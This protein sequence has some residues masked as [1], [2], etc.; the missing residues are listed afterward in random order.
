[1]AKLTVNI[2]TT[3]NDRTGDNL[4]TAFTKINTNFTE[5][6]NDVENLTSR[7]VVVEGS[8]QTGGLQ[9]NTLISNVQGSI[10]AEDSTILVNAANNTLQGD[11]TGDVTG[12]IKGNVFG[13]DSSL[14]V[15]ADNNTVTADLTGN[16]TG[17]VTGNVTGNVTGDVTGNLTG[18]VV[19][20]VFG[21]DS[22]LIVDATNNTLSG[23]LTG[24]VVGN[25]TGD[26]TGNITSS[27]TNTFTG[28][29]SFTGATVTGLAVSDVEGDI[30]GSVFA[31]DSTLLVDGVNA[32]IPS[33]NLNGALPAIAGDAITIDNVA[34]KK[35]INT[36]AVAMSVGLS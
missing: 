19:G 21:Q 8:G 14:I 29:V 9:G 12:S 32:N 30:K 27:G 25:V 33:A 7:L 24:D 13:E 18:D 35:R 20:S 16:V 1:M 11:L 34:I 31:D 4:R 28:T 15:D 10:I 26:V 2:G 3:A 36:L 5:V 17:D 22:T 6:Y 23:N